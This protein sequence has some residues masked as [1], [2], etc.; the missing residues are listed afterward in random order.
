MK[1]TASLLCLLLVTFCCNAQITW[2]KLFVQSNTDVFRSVQEVPAGG[3]IAAGYTSHWSIN[4]TD[5]YVVRLTVNGDTMWTRTFNGGKQ[6]LFYKVIN[7]ADG[8]FVMC[9]YSSSY[10]VD[11]NQDAY[12]MKLD[13]NGNELWHFTYGGIQKERAQDIIQTADGGYAMCGYSNSGTGAQ[14]YNSFLVKIDANGGQTWSM[15]Y[16]GNGFD[17]ANSVKEI[18][19]GGDFIMAGQS[20]S[21]PG[22]LGLGDIWLVRTN[23]TGGLIWTQRIGT[24]GNDNAEYLQLATAGGFIICGSTDPSAVGDDNG[25]IVKT[26][27]AGT[28]LWSRIYGGTSPDDFHRVENTTDG[29]YIIT[30]TSQSNASIISDQWLFKTDLNGDSMWAHTFGGA[31]HDHAYS[32][33]QT[34]DGGYILCGYTASFGFNYEDA[35]VIKV[36]G[37]GLLYNHLFYTTVTA[38]VSPVNGSC[39]SANSI[40]TITVRNF[41]DTTLSS[42]PDTVIITGAI[43]QTLGQTFGGTIVPPNSAN[44]TFTSTINTSAGGT[45]NFHCFTSNNN[46]VYPAMNS[47]DATI[48]LNGLPVPPTAIGDTSCGTGSVTLTATSPNTINWFSASTGG[49]SLASGSSYTT[50]ISSTTTFYVQASNACGTS[51][52]TAV[53]AYVFPVTAAPLVFSAQRCGPGN[54]T[55]LASSGSPISWWNSATGGIMLQGNINS[56]VAYVTTTTTFYV[57]AGTGSTCPSARVPVTAT[58]NPFPDANFTPNASAVCLGDAFQFTNT[59]TGAVGYVW[60]F[61]DAAGTSNQLNPS[62]TYTMTGTYLVRLIA[63][64]AQSCQD[65]IIIPVNVNTAPQVSFSVPSTTGCAPFT[66]S[67]I[68]T[69]INATDYLWSLGDGTATSIAQNPTY[70]YYMPGTYTV[71]L[72]AS[73]GSCSEADTNFNYITV[74]PSPAANFSTANVCF[75]DVMN[76]TNSSTGATSYTWDFGD[77]S[78][79]SAQTDP[80]YTYTSANTYIV[81]LVASDGT[82]T[83]TISQSVTAYAPPVIDLGPDITTNSVSYLLDAGAGF[84]GYAWNNGSTTQTITADTNGVYCVVVTDNNTCSNMDCIHVTVDAAGISYISGD[85]DLLIYPNPVSQF[86]VCNILFEGKTTGTLCVYDAVGNQVLKMDLLTSCQLPTAGLQAGIY[87]IEIKSGNKNVRRKLMIY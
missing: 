31:N 7:T 17:D 75:G 42:F 39:G 19:P 29:G 38:L 78:G 58:V 87:F 86:A 8:G 10:T 60:D 20:N 9:G 16:G 81:S 67:F 76:F 68:N 57:E 46:D 34:S 80:S 40:V 43:N 53:T 30:G 22:G 69:T 2:E 25:Y 6:D 63:T 48:T 24:A 12:Y 85:Y 13:A 59:T 79:T 47:Y 83:D 15:K 74:I 51:T 4:D 56:Y 62:Y 41:G 73:V 37:S 36:D 66:V 49:S 3:Y 14:G 55:L 21:T 65:T 77:A 27:D 52:R 5:A 82:C 72:N 71:S 28:V 32:G 23:S 33:V 11:A 26:D 35:L 1:R 45:F 50:T 44:H 18:L 54:V 84:A 70:T 61:G 64:S